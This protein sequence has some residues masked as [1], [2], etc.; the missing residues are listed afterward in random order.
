ME[1]ISMHGHE[2]PMISSMLFLILLPKFGVASSLSVE[3]A[4][5]IVVCNQVVTILFPCF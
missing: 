1:R 5:D 4:S 2:L 3:F